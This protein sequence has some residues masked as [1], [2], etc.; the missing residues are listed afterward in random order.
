MKTKI[1]LLIL[2]LMT[3]LLVGCT[4]NVNARDDVSIENWKE[5]KAIYARDAGKADLNPLVKAGGVAVIDSA[6]AYEEAKEDND[7]GQD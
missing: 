2:V 3:S 7:D 4:V 5:V 6:L 1:R